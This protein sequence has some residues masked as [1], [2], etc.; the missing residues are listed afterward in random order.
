MEK[1]IYAGTVLGNS[2]GLHIMVKE[3]RIKDSRRGPRGM[4]GKR[5]MI[6]GQGKEKFLVL[7]HRK[8]TIL[9]GVV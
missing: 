6:T 5:D 3:E 2:K 9:R 7:K 8:K 1:K 4:P